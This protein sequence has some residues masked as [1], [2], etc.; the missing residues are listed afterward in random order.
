MYEMDLIC[1]AVVAIYYA[2]RWVRTFHPAD[3][4]K[5]AIATAAGTLVRYDAWALALALTVVV[6][7]VAWRA[8]GRVVAEA[9][10]L[11]FGVMG[12]AGCAA[13]LIYQQ[14]IFGDPLEFLTGPYSAK[15]QEQQIQN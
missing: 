11:L 8:R 12:F 7:F 14:V 2:V 9:N 6:L 10:L 13:W 1:C 15:A 4:V 3:L 5:A